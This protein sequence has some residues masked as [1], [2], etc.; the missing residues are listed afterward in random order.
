MPAD[1]LYGASTARAVSN[2]TISGVKVPRRVISALACIKYAAAKA[3]KKAGVLDGDVA[4]AISEAAERVMCPGSDILS[5]DN[6]PV[7]IFQTGSGTSSNMN[8]NEV[9]SSLSTASL[10]RLVHPNDAVNM[11]QSSNDCFPAAVRIATAT[12][13]RDDVIPSLK[14][15]EASLAAKGEEIWPVLHCARTHLQDALP[16]RLGSLFVGHAAQMRGAIAKCEQAMQDVCHIS[17]GTAVGTAYGASPSF[18]TEVVKTLA[19]H[20]HLPLQDV[21]PTAKR[22]AAQ[23]T[24]DDML[25][26]SQALSYAA[27]SIA[28]VANDIRWLSAGPRCGLHEITMPT[29]Q[30]GSSMMPGKGNPVLAEALL[31]TCCAVLGGNVSLEHASLLMSNFELAVAWP[32][33]STVCVTHGQ[34]LANA[35]CKF[36]RD[37]VDGISATDAG[38]RNAASSLMLSTALAQE[39]GYDAAASVAKDAGA[40][41]S[42]LIEAALRTPE[43][44]QLGEQ[45]LAEMLDPKRLL[46]PFDGPHPPPA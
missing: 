31:Q 29:L 42:T 28:K 36:S 44:Q 17:F 40:T 46:G 10:G 21:T 38:P 11:G 1:A 35:T 6:F 15:L 43:G 14:V 32:L 23:S 2:F 30:P 45:R 37:A 25:A 24:M 8:V 27:M 16:T 4:D 26:A 20:T 39:M 5:D 41:A 9:L 3:N 34:W 18:S 7:D 19:E 33:A 12:T 22:F 13:M